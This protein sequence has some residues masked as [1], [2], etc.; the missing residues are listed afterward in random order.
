MINRISPSSTR[1]LSTELND[2]VLLLQIEESVLSGECLHEILWLAIRDAITANTSASVIVISL[3]NV[4]Q[5]TS[6]TVSVFLRA[7]RLSAQHSISLRLCEMS[8]G[9]RNVFKILRLDGTKLVIVDT[10]EE[11]IAQGSKVPT[12]F[13][14][15]LGWEEDLSGLDL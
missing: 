13:D 1:F 11:G 4:K 12:L 14:A 8:A 15:Y 3:G 10:I 6:L 2:D 5:L 7:V 9:I